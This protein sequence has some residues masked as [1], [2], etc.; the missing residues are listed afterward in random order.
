MHSLRQRYGSNLVHT[1]A[2]PNMVVINP[3]S[4][5]SMYSEKVSCSLCV[6]WQ[7]SNILNQNKSM[8]W[9]FSSCLSRWCRC[10]R[11]AGRRTRLLTSTAQPR[12]P[13]GTSSPLDRI[14]PSFF[15]ERVGVERPPTVSILSSTS[16][17]SLAAPTRPSLVGGNWPK[18]QVRNNIVIQICF[19]VCSREMAGSLHRVRG[20]WECVHLSEWKCQSLLSCCFLGLWP[21]RSGD[22]S[23]HSGTYLVL[24]L[25]WLFSYVSSVKSY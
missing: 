13:T 12:L 18:F 22:F 14:S 16:L 10:S 7:F 3:I 6:W 17:L 11:A 2:G 21:G 19:V 5:P 4:S 23:L 8:I 25:L 1:H 24:S 9:I 15:W 20:I